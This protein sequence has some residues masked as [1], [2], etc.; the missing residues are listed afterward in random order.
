MTTEFTLLNNHYYEITFNPHDDHQ[1]FGSDLRHIKSRDEVNKLFDTLSCNYLLY[2][3]ISIQQHANRTSSQNRV[4]Y[5]GVIQVKDAFFF[6]L[7]HMYKLAKFGDYQL[8]EYRPE[9]LKYCTKQK[10]LYKSCIIKQKQSI[11]NCD[12]SYWKTLLGPSEA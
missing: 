7:T 10:D 12:S 8:N 11:S 1:Y 2:Q 5:H 9:W 3:E 4:H 6:S